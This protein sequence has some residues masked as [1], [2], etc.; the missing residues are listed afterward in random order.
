MLNSITPPLKKQFPEPSNGDSP[1]V[2]AALNGND[3]ETNRNSELELNNDSNTTSTNNENTT[4]AGNDTDTINSDET[5][6][7]VEEFQYYLEKSQQLFSGLRELSP[8]SGIKQ[9]QP[10][11]QRTFE[12]YTKLWKFQQKHR[13]TLENKDSYGLRRW[14][15]GEISSKIGQ[16]YYHYYLRTSE[17]SYLQESC[18]F[19][20]AIWERGYFQDVLEAK[21]PALMIKKL[22]YYARFIVVC[23]LLNKSEIAKKL[24]I[25]LNQLVEDYT[26][27][28]K[29]ADHMEWQLVLQEIS[30]FLEAERK[31]FYQITSSDS[32]QFISIKTRSVKSL[33]ELKY[34]NEGDI[35]PSASNSLKLQE[36]LLTANHPNQA[37]FSEMTVDMFRMVQFFERETSPTGLQRSLTNN[38]NQTTESEQTDSNAADKTPPK[39]PNPHKNL[40]Y[41]PTFSQLLLYLANAYKECQDNSV[42]LVYLSGE[43]TKTSNIESNGFVGGFVTSFRKPINKSAEIQGSVTAIHCLHPSDL[44]PFTRKPLFLVVDSQNANIYAQLPKVFNQPVL[45]LLSASESLFKDTSQGSLFTL[46]LHSPI[47][48]ISFIG[49]ITE[50]SAEVSDNC[51]ELLRSLEC[52]V[53]KELANSDSPNSS[54][55]PFLYDDFL[56]TLCVRFLI[57][58]N[59]LQMH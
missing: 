34:L 2:S 10:Y 25:E 7:L 5:S 43:A 58:H 57:L 24:T 9:W 8:I 1:L 4:T 27:L 56:R 18:V 29:P 11:F 32:K 31:P 54:I 13:V 14:E 41:R 3:A 51:L 16:L 55:H 28:F 17:L 47:L 53:F 19:Y 42:L 46:F 23:L 35:L 48:G 44:V 30:L 33:A 39:R 59:L 15:V 20:E 49:E 45:C 38:T 36:V 6:K 52:L 22:R 21:N 26:K 40:L 37:K 50:L 12:I